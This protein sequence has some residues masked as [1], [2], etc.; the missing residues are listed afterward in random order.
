MAETETNHGN[1]E[2]YLQ[3]IENLYIDLDNLRD[4]Y[5]TQC[6]EVRADI[7][8]VYREARDEGL[9]AKALKGI[10]KYRALERRQQ[11][12]DK[13][14]DANEK[15]AFDDLVDRLG[16]LGRAAAEASGHYHDEQPRFA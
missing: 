15:A 4:D 14:F 7:Q 9:E 1:A 3:R 10:V 5:R 11:Q 2:H 6:K 12:I 16:D 8:A 13:D